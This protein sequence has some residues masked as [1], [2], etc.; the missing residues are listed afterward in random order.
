[1]GY[2]CGIQICLCSDSDIRFGFGYQI[3]L[4]FVCLWG[5]IVCVCRLDSRLF[6]TIGLVWWLFVTVVLNCIWLLVV[7]GCVVFW[8]LWFWYERVT[9]NF[10]IVVS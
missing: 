3:D 6:F 2:T 8:V 7:T 5:W 10:E 4:W 9:G 1:M